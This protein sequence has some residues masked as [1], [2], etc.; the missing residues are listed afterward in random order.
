MTRKS[1]VNSTEATFSTASLP[2]H[3]GK[4]HVGGKLDAFG[5][6]GPNGL[7]NCVILEPLGRSFEELLIMA[8]LNQDEHHP[9]PSVYDPT[10]WSAKFL[11]EVCR[12]IILA[13]DFLHQ[14][15]IMHR[16]MQPGNVLLAL[17]YDIHSM[18]EAEIEQDLWDVDNLPQDAEARDPSHQPSVANQSFGLEWQKMNFKRSFF[19]LNIMKRLDGEPLRK[20]DPIYIVGPTS[21]RDRLTFDPPA[22]FKVILNDLESFCCFEDCN[23]GQITYPIDVCSHKSILAY[24]MTRKPTY[25]P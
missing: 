13:L 10:V 1:N 16:D 6:K 23:D 14:N 9:K 25:G 4:D 7:H 24:R 5:L 8:E 17:T 12:Q 11:R 18:T 21:L 2:D 19:S 20:G 22:D 15:Q 3:P